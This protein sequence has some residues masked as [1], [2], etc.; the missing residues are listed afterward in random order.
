MA[1]RHFGNRAA[2]I[3]QGGEQIFMLRRINPVVT[4]GQY[5]DRAA[6]DGRA[7]R[8]LIDAARQSGDNNKTS[9][10]E[11]AGDCAREFQPGT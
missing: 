8:G 11:I 4:A 5:G 1:E 2:L 9:L 7:M 3:E 10:P 6:F